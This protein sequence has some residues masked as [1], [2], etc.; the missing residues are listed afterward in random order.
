MFKGFILSESLNNPLILN[1]LQ[2]EY[3][4]IEKHSEANNKYPL[5]W[6]LFKVSVQDNDIKQTADNIAKDI[7]P[8]WYAHFWNGHE[9]YICFTNKVFV[10]P[11]EKHWSSSQYQEVI[12][13]AKKNGIEERYLDFLIED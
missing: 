9:V 3:V 13:Y 4:K 7:K 5:Y 11:H 8:D 10:I 2:K 6:H 1:S 12:E